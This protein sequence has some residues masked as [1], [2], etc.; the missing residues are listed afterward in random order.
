MR[1]KFRGKRVSGGEW[2][3]GDLTKS[4]VFSDYD[5]VGVVQQIVTAWDY[6]ILVHEP[7]NGLNYKYKEC[8]V[9][10][11]TIGQFTGLLDVN[12][13]EIFEGDEIKGTVYGCFANSREVSHYTIAFVNGGFY[14]KAT[15]NHG[16]E[17]DY[18]GAIIHAHKI[19]VI[20]N[21]HDKE[22][23]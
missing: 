10:P 1:Y 9:D 19:D 12:G 14:L 16:V 15:Y 18:I 21:I 7:N 3:Y 17:T 6:S 5:Y 13:V 4:K 8:L 20:G 23:N 22:D 2:V 11:N